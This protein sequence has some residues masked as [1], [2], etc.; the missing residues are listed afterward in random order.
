MREIGIGC[1][2]L[3][4]L[5][6]LGF[7]EV[8]NIIIVLIM[9]GYFFIDDWKKNTDNNRTTSYYNLSQEDR[10]KWIYEPT[11]KED[12]EELYKNEFIIDENGC[13]R[14]KGKHL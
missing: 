1:I 6:L 4:I 10:N 5:H 14:Y 13:Y 2:V 12:I 8:I 9:F 3:F 7:P 11:S